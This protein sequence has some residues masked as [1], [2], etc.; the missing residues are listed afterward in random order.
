MQTD[1]ELIERYMR[2]KDERAFEAL[3]V[4]YLGLATAILAVS[5]TAAALH[6]QGKRHDAEAAR[7]RSENQRMLSERGATTRK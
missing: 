2:A 3:V 1:A 7:L 4:R 6:L 5:I